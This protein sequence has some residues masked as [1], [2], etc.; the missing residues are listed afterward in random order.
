MKNYKGTFLNITILILLLICGYLIYSL[1]FSSKSV[2][3]V[4][5]SNM[6]DTNFKITDINIKPTAEVLN[7]CGEKK[8]ASLFTNYLIEKGV[9]VKNSG[10]YITDTVQKT[11]ILLRGKNYEKAKLVANVIGIDSTRIIQNYNKDLQLDVTIIIGKDFYTLKPY[12]Y[13]NKK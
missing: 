1:I 4:Q 8:L 11:L 7:G 10:N 6:T 5:V 3:D 13:Q 9:D 12:L 2:K